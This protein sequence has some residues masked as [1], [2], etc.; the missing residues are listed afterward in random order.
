M[1]R[2]REKGCARCWR[3]LPLTKEHFTTAGWNRTGKRRRWDSYCKLCRCEHQREVRQRVKESPYALKLHRKKK[4]ANERK[5]RARNP[6]RCHAAQHSWYQRMKQD[7]ERYAAYLER[8]RMNHRLRE[9]QRGRVVT[10]SAST[11]KMSHNPRHRLPV[12]P[13]IGFLD[14]L[15]I[16]D[17]EVGRRS[18]LNQRQV[19]RIRHEAQNVELKVADAIVTGVGEF[20]LTDVWDVCDLPL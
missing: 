13:L 11:A 14:R 12:A 3:T 19:W 15:A 2:L 4:A 1:P 9:E 16:S 20:T 5:R 18:G 8:R 6:E 17:G 10:R 7:P